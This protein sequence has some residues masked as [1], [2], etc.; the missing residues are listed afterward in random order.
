MISIITPVLNESPLIK[1]FIDHLNTLSGEFE[2]ILVDGGSTDNT[3]NEIKKNKR[4]FKNKLKF[5][6]TSQ[7]RGNQMNKGATIATGEIYLFLHI[8]CK[9]EKDVLSA[10]EREIKEN[11]II[12]GGMIQMFTDSDRFLTI[13]SNFG[14]LRSKITQIFFGDCGIFIKKDVFE[15]IGGYDDIVFL[16]DVEFCR[17][18]KKYGKLKQIDFQIYTS[19]RR[20]ISIGKLKITIIFTLAYFLN[21]L[22]FRPEYLKKFIVK[23]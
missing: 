12:G 7:G 8:D 6:T 13:A 14:N 11:R 16:E 21:L 5:V 1:P 9:I 19:S 18:A 15:K 10:I 3:V 4:L 22:N 23:K 20:Y 2:L 17:K